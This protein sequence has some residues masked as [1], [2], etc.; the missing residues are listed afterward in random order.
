MLIQRI[1]HVKNKFLI[2]QM[3]ERVE[4]YLTQSSLIQE[5]K[6]KSKT[7]MI[8]FNLFKRQRNQILDIFLS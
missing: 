8:F 3:A 7:A 2:D 1:L 5:N 4:K 6:M